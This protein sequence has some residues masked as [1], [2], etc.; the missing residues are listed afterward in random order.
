MALVKLL[1]KLH[2]A[3]GLQTLIFNKKFRFFFMFDICLNRCL[4]IPLSVLF[5]FLTPNCQN[6]EN[7]ASRKWAKPYKQN[8]YA[9][10]GS[11]NTLNL[12]VLSAHFRIVAVVRQKVALLLLLILLLF[13][14]GTIFQQQLGCNHKNLPFGG[15]WWLYSHTVDTWEERTSTNYL[16]FWS[17]LSSV[18][19]VYFMY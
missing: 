7:Y 4:S 19:E 15:L 12:P 2:W 17:L 8:P 9:E 18:V 14:Y 5:S 3:S 10:E 11:R 13:Y 1:I 16:N 6:E